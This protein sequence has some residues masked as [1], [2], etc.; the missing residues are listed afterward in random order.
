MYKTLNMK[1]TQD[2][3][4]LNLCNFRLEL[5]NTLC[6]LGD[7]SSNG[8]RG[9]PSNNTLEAELQ[10]KKKRGPTQPVPPKGV[11]LDSIGHWQTFGDRARCKYPG[12]KGYTY[13]KCEKC[14]L[15]LCYNKDNNCFYKFHHL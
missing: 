12:C 3:T 10:M 8:K 11:R 6:K 4:P 13:T 7:Q 5:T 14:R 9:R 15:S 1:N 2:K